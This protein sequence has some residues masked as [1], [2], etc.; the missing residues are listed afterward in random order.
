MIDEIG[1]RIYDVGMLIFYRRHIGKA[2]NRSHYPYGI[3]SAKL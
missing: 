1:N 2:E 3:K